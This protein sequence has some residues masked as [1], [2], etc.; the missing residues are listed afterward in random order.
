MEQNII[1][2]ILRFLIHLKLKNIFIF[3]LIFLFQFHLI[4]FLKK[5]IIQKNYIFFT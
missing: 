3:L 5:V 1:F 4:L 2:F